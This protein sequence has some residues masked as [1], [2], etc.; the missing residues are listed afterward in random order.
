[1]NQKVNKNDNDQLVV[2]NYPRIKQPIIQQQ[3]FKPP[4]FP[5]WKQNLCLEFDKSYYCKN[6]EY[7]INKQ[8][9]QIGKKVLS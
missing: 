4:N 8:Q 5:T 9:H 7:I 3:K 2:K 1:M 6:C